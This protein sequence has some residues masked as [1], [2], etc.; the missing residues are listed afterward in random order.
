MKDE[1]FKSWGEQKFC[2]NAAVASV[3]DDMINRSV[4]FYSLSTE[5]ICSL[6][7]ERL[8]KN[9]RVIDLGCSVANTLIALSKLRAD[10]ELVGI[11]ESGAMLEQAKNKIIAHGAKIELKCA[12]ITQSSLGQG[13]GAVI[14]NYTLQ[15]IDP[16]KRADFIAKIA[17]SLKKGGILILSEKLKCDENIATELTQI[18][19]NYKVAQ[20][21]SAIEIA[22]KREALNDVLIPF[23][24]QENKEL[25]LNAGFKGFECVFRWANFATFVAIN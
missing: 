13:N 12:D 5:L 17:K 23:S 4:P 9:E 7:A 21:Y 10:L 19:E 24:E 20:G 8:G 6:L 2:F 3:F 18:Y 11:D 1:L 15:F 14:L 22:K 25:C 16:L